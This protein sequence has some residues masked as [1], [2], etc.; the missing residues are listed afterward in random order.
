GY[1][2]LLRR[3]SILEA[4]VNALGMP[5]DWRDLQA[6]VLVNQNG[7]FLDFHVVDTDPKRAKAIADE[8][9]RQLVLQS[10]TA[11]D[12]RQVEDQRAFM[13]QQLNKLRASITQAEGELADKQAAVEKETSARGV[14]DLQDE[15]KALEAKLGGWRSTYAALI[16]VDQHK[17]PTTLTVVE[18]AF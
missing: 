4:T 5:T 2:N 11:D 17:G 3:Q 16:G 12:L 8:I 6:R 15:I 1:A 9:T 13:A 14:L 7:Q 10:P 18:P